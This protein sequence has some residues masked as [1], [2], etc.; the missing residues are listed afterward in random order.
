MESFVG[1]GTDNP[2]LGATY[3]SCACALNGGAAYAYTVN[4]RTHHGKGENR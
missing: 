1:Q 4:P 3:L 2:K